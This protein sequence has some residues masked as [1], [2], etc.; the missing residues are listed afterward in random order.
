M[1]S[2]AAAF[3]ERLSSSENHLVVLD[4]GTWIHHP[5]PEVHARSQNVA[6]WLL[7]DEVTALGLIGEPTVELIAAI[8]GASSPGPRCRSS[9]DPCAAPNRISGRSRRFP[10]SPAWSSATSSARARTFNGWPSSTGS[11]WSRTRFRC[12]SQAL[13]HLRA[14][15]ATGSGGHPARHRRVNGSPT[16][17]GAF[18]RCRAGQPA[19]SQRPH[20]SDACRRRPLVATALP[21]HGIE[22]PARRCAR[23]HRCVAGADVR[24]S[25]VPV[26][27]AEL[28]DRESGH[29]HRP[30]RRRDHDPRVVD[31]VGYRGDTPRDADEWFPTGDL[32]CFAD[33]GLVVC[34]RAKELITV[35]G[36]NIFPAEVERVAA[37]ARGVREGAVVAVG[38]GE[39]SIRPGV[40][41]V[42]EFRG[43]DE[44]DVRADVNRRV[45]SECGVVP[46]DVVFVRPGTLPRTTSGNLRRLEAKRDLEASRAQM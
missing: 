11:R 38:V 30:R 33:G 35:A 17:S 18:T 19:W 1:S 32:G 40:V 15:V 14:P 34:G 44:A 29:D 6:E 20:R 27:V 4:D 7:N 21:R 25:S 23:R 5:W 37:T 8:L 22:L 10:A 12:A 24:F 9:P 46:S 39:R 41:I 2:L 3:A 13:G 31:D 45:A 36:R 43:P 42:A 16:D 28:A 26:P